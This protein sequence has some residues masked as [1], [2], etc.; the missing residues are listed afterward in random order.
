MPAILLVAI[1]AKWIH[2]SLALRL[3]KANLG[4]L[5]KDCEI[6]EFALRQPL[7]EKIEPIITAR[8]RL[9]GISVSIWNHLATLELLKALGE[10]WEAGQEAAQKP[11]VVLGGP[12]ASWLG[13]D[14]E[15]FRYAD[16]VIR[17]EGE[18]CFR[19]LCKMVFSG[20]R[21]EWDSIAKSK[22]HPVFISLALNA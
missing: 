2:P 9:L 5:E 18:D 21:A 12:E 17:G 22:G 13:K 1:N 16:Y 20:D 3:L 14:A 7:K 10:K 19:A 6:F 11:V 8:P 15:I 4:D